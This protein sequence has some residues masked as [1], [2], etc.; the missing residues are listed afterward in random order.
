[1]VGTMRVIPILLLALAAGCAATSENGSGAGEP[2]RHL[3][4]V[5]DGLRPDY[6]TPEHMPNLTALG[7]RGVVYTRHHAVYPTVTRVN[8]SSFSTGAYPE[9]HGLLGNSVF[10]PRVDPAAFLTT[11]ES[12]VLDRIAAVEGQ[13][14]TATTLG[15]VLERQGRRMLVVSSGSSGSAL[16]N[17]HTIA[18]GAV[19]H[20]AIVRPETL[21]AGMPPVESDPS[22]GPRPEFD[23][24]AVD[25]LLK[26]GIPQVDPSVTVLWLG[27]LDATAHAN[28]IGAPATLAVLRQVDAEIGR[29]QDGLAALGLL[30]QYNIWVTSDHG[31]STYTGAPAV[32]AVLAPYVKGEGAEASIVMSGGAIYVRDE[33]PAVVGDI[34]KALQRTRGVGAIFTQAPEPGALDGAVPGTL[35]FDAIRWRHARSA[36]ILYSPDWTDDRNAHGA[37]GTSASGGTAGHGS[38]SPWDVHNTLI[39]AG[40]DI[41]QGVTL[42]VPSGNVDFAPTFL[43]LLGIDAPASMQGR[44][45]KEALHGGAPMPAVTTTDHTAATPD[46]TYAV[47]A[48]FST[49]RGAD[50]RTYR[51]FDG[52]RVARAST[53]AAS[54]MSSN[55]RKRLAGS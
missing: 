54:A 28:G 9:H 43:A 15:E 19:L 34:V 23:A 41:R 10:M 52:A 12:E 44:V 42:D 53:D 24:H 22:L 33:S 46:G 49:V 18:G 13:L 45:L 5:V 40:P 38:T 25:T 8:A 7:E 6:V 4:I 2:R 31:F 20:R 16:L 36:Q 35:S 17:N 50:G 29:V 32:N 39:A 1:M 30:D 48:T 37:Q 11:S 14:L 51:Y 21:R 3:L 26:V 47:T 27:A 55:E